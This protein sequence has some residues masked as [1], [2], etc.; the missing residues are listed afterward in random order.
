LRRATHRAIAAATDDLEALRF[1]R[2]VARIYELANAIS[3]AEA[4]VAGAVRRE[5]LETLVLLVNPMM[6]HLAETCWQSLGHK[7]M[8]VETAWPAADPDLVRQDTLTIAVQVNGKRRGEIEIARNAD[9]KSVETA[10][11]ALEG[12]VRA[13]DGKPPKRVIVVPERIVNIVA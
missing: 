5:A 8:V 10:A 13:L 3:G 2:A 12:V 9:T 6:P 1:N 11:L 7:T 4:G